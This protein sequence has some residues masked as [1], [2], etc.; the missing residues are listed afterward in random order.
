MIL[1]SQLRSDAQ[2][3]RIKPNIFLS[4]DKESPT[5]PQPKIFYDLRATI[6]QMEGVQRDEKIDIC[7]ELFP[8]PDIPS[9]GI[10]LRRMAQAVYRKLLRVEGSADAD[11]KLI[12]GQETRSAEL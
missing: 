8:R 12:I 7:R 5:G 3:I 9:R 2:Q 11:L 4:G 6:V 10:A 1:E